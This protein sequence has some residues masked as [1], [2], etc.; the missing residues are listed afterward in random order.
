MLQFHKIFFS[1][2][3]IWTFLLKLKRLWKSK[4]FKC[5]FVKGFLQ[6]CWILQKIFSQKTKQR[7]KGPKKTRKNRYFSCTTHGR[8]S[9]VHFPLILESKLKKYRW[10]MCIKPRKQLL[11][12]FNELKIRLVSNSSYVFTNLFHEFFQW[13]YLSLSNWKRKQFFYYWSKTAFFSQFVIW[14]RKH[15]IWSLKNRRFGIQDWWNYLMNSL[16]DLK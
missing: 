11:K 8:C 10:K 3:S 5:N 9:F 2:F 13:I 6:L 1:I 14:K 16:L 15:N 4:K 12:W 7:D